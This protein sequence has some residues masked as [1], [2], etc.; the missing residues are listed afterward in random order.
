MKNFK[1]Y[2]SV[3]VL[4]IA[5]GCATNPLT[6]KKGLALVDNN[7]IFPQAFQQYTQFLSENKVITGTPQAKMVESVG[8]K[9][10]QAAEK[11]YAAL[12]QSNALKDYQ[13]EYKL[14]ESKDVNAWCMPGGKIVF[15][16][17]I[18][19]ITKDEA[20]MACVM[21]HE[22]AHALLNHGQ[23]RMSAGMLQQLGAGAVG[24]A[25]GNKSAQTQQLW[26]TAYGATTQYA[27]MLPFSR[28]HESEADEIG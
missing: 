7:S 27:G 4:G 22:V 9:I 8:M 1:I 18:L 23:Q 15:Y 17:G 11:W 13:W 24:A 26:M 3:I 19:P 6:G 20:G 10:K 28:N 5:L 25:V 21:G 2:L 16:T 14:V 12:G